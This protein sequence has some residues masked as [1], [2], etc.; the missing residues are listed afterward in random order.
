[1]IAT[2][3]MILGLVLARVGGFVAFLPLF[4][5][6]TVPRRVKA[7]LA[8]ALTGFWFGGLDPHALPTLAIQAGPAAWLAVTLAAI[9]E[10]V[11]G[12]VLGYGFGL[13][14]LPARVAGEFLTQQMGLSVVTALNPGAEATTGTVTQFFETLGILIFLGLDGHHLFL[15]A[16]HAT[17]TTWPVGGPGTPLPLVPVLNGVGRTQEWGLLLAA[18]LGVCLFLTSV[19]LAFMARAAP[20]LNIYSVGFTLQVGVALVA[21]L[22]LL[23][24]VGALLVG[25][26]GRF[27]ELVAEWL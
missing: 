18:P 19:L 16:L 2:W 1:M 14:L 13:V 5:G 12:A 11:L 17:F 6:H 26:F 4:G 9:R 21:T 3:V 23:P 10:A 8:V 24:E 7:G 27:G 20:Q 22:L 25:I 15:A